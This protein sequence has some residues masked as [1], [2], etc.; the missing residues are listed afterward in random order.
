VV[1]PKELSVPVDEVE[2]RHG[3]GK[4]LRD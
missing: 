2:N 4:G 1:G 3:E